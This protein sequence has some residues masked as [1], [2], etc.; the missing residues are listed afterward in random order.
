MPDGRAERG[1]GGVDFITDGIIMQTIG[2]EGMAFLPFLTTLFIFILVCNIF[3][4]IPVIQFPA[5]A[6]MAMPL[7]L[8]LIIW[9]LY[10]FMGFKNQGFGGTSRSSLFPPGV[11]KALYI[12]VTPSSSCRPSSSGPSRWPSGS[13]PTCWPATCC[14]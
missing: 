2:P 8:A 14:W 13:S 11:P 3:E 7:F 12:L 10:I 6:R 1:R 9:V 4:V 5:N